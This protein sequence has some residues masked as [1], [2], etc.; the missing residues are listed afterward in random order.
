MDT[1]GIVTKNRK[2]SFTRPL[3]CMAIFFSVVGFFFFLAGFI[4]A[5][6]KWQR[7]LKEPVVDVNTLLAQFRE[8]RARGKITETEYQTIKTQLSY[9]IRDEMRDAKR[10]R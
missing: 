3:A 7:S 1:R 6:V 2:L 5:A 9:Q 4:Y 10:H 8:F